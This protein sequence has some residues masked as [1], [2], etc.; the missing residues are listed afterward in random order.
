MAKGKAKQKATKATIAK[1]P[2]LSE[3][4]KG[5]QKMVVKGGAPRMPRVRA[6]PHH[7]C[8]SH[9]ALTTLACKCRL[10]SSHHRSRKM[11]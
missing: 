3:K 1:S 2:P 4:A 5:K 7:N 6:A 11:S 9:V 10:H 8:M